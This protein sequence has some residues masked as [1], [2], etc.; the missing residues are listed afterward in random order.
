MSNALLRLRV[1]R[2]YARAY[3]KIRLRNGQGF[4]GS[5]RG[6]GGGTR[7]R[8]GKH[9]RTRKKKSGTRK[10][11]PE[12]T[13]S[14]ILTRKTISFIIIIM[15][16]LRARTAAPRDNTFFPTRASVQGATT[17]TTNVGQSGLLVPFARHTQTGYDQE[18]GSRV[19]S[20]YDFTE[21]EFV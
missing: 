13:S 14:V 9:Y 12:H 7:T 5:P 15:P 18:G 16:F 1:P 11:F 21:R 20:I 6:G 8:G 3:I 4:G 2:S 19:K 17:T 10:K